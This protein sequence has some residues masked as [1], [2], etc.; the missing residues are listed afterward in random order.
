MI[1]YVLLCVY[2][3]ISR[4]FPAQDAAVDTVFSLGARGWVEPCPDC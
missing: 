2:A 1:T 4:V 3:V